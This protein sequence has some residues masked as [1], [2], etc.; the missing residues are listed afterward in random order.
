MSDSGSQASFT[1]RW[2]VSI[3]P[4]RANQAWWV[5]IDAQAAQVAEDAAS[6]SWLW[7][8]GTPSTA[9]V[10]GARKVLRDACLGTLVPPEE[11]EALAEAIR[12][13][14][15]GPADR[16]RIA[17]HAQR[18]TLSSVGSRVLDTYGQAMGDESRA[19]ETSQP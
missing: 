3:F 13:V 11:P 18:F 10:G 14:L 7:F 8:S 4:T 15:D 6:T 17:S 1:V 12:H 19:R 5:F 2:G 9:S 16:D